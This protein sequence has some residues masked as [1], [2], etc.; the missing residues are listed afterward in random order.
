VGGVGGGGEAAG[1]EGEQQ[2]EQQKKQLDAV[3]SLVE[4]LNSLKNTNDPHAAEEGLRLLE[5][6]R[7]RGIKDLRAYNSA[8]RVRGEAATAALV[9]AVVVF[10]T[11][12]GI[13]A[14]G[15]FLGLL[16]SLFCWNAVMELAYHRYFSRRTCGMV[17]RGR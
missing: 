3:I 4:R 9:S 1:E 10:V 17:P 2:K 12:F 6:G 11:V 5:E 15:I 14:V 8:L 7:S 16:T 13:A